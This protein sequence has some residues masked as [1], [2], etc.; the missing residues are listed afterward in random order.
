MPSD[1]TPAQ[2]QEILRGAMGTA[3]VRFIRASGG[4]V[5]VKLAEIDENLG[6][7]FHVTGD[8][9]HFI[10]REAPPAPKKSAIVLAGAGAMNGLPKPPR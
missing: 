7:D 8:A 2:M 5:Q 3:F 10:V 4:Q 1:L 9:A 6:F